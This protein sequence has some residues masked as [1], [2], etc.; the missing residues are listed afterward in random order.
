MGYLLAA[1]LG[2]FF[3]FNSMATPEKAARVMQSTLQKQF[4]GAQVQTEVEGKRGRAVLKGR[5]KRVRINMSNFR[6]EGV[7]LGSDQKTESRGEIGRFEVAL[8]NFSVPLMGGEVPV[9]ALQM[10]FNDVVYDRGVL[11]KNSQIRLIS[12][13][14]GDAQLTVTSAAL[15]TVLQAKF[16][17]IKNL[18][19]AFGANNAV[20]VTGTRPAPVFGTPINVQLKG[21]VEVRN[22]NQILLANPQ[23][24]MGGL[25]V[26]DRLAENFTGNLNPLYTFDPERKAPIRVDITNVQIVGNLALLTAKL[27]V[28]PTS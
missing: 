3:A 6:L 14:P 4:P 15:Q 9:Q 27:T 22:G 28:M 17:E 10:N 21:R 18:K 12:A 11:K 5:F 1:L 26:P 13:A 20:T 19:L 2:G 8:N 25:P 24:Q 7:P 23:V 16:K